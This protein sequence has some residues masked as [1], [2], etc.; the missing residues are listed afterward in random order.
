MIGSVDSVFLTEAVRV[1]GKDTQ[2]IAFFQD[3][4]IL[5]AFQKL[6]DNG[7]C[8]FLGIKGIIGAE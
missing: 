5:P 3:V 6:S 1:K 8:I 2:D 7:R 4:M